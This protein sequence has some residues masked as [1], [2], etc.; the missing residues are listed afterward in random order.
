MMCLKQRWRR[1]E[2]ERSR[3]VVSH[4]LFLASLIGSIFTLAQP[5]EALAAPRLNQQTTRVAQERAF[6]KRLDFYEPDEPDRDLKLWAERMLGLYL[7]DPPRRHASERVDYSSDHLHFHLWRPIGQRSMVELWSEAASWLTFGRIKYS[8]GARG[9]FGDLGTLKRVTVSLHEVIRPKQ[10]G[11]RL[12]KEPDVV[13]IYLTISLTRA[14]FERLDL[15]AL[16]SCALNSNCD[17]S[18]RSAFSLVKLNSR[19]IKRRRR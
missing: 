10:E 11:R 13:E 18:M 4:A 19:Y 17:R 2:V 16:R 7:V 8:S 3:F 14:D 9:L 1:A 15:D 6:P 12:S 5:Q